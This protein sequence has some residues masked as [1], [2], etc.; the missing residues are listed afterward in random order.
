MKSYYPFK[1]YT[2]IIVARGRIL[3]TKTISCSYEDSESSEYIKNFSFFATS[4]HTPKTNVL[5]F[6]VHN[7]ELVSS[8]VTVRMNSD[9]KNFIE[10]DVIKD[11]NPS[12][13]IDINVKTNQNSYIGLLGIDKSSKLLRSGNDLT[14]ED[15]WNEFG[16]MFQLKNE[17]FFRKNQPF[18]KNCWKSFQVSKVSINLI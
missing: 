14:I 6:N 8:N 7:K 3:E 2:Y 15:V 17:G 16:D 13:I 4:E 10:L 1:S 18:Y 9:F 11:A 5:I 12:Q